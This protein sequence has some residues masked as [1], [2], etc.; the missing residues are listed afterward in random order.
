M[1][2]TDVNISDIQLVMDTFKVDND[3]AKSMILKGLNP[4]ILRNGYMLY[5]NRLNAI[6]KEVESLVNSLTDE[7]IKTTEELKHLSKSKQNKT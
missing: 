7:M 4:S 1:L 3:R 2:D 6:H 5:G